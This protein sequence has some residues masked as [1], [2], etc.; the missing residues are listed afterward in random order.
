MNKRETVA[1]F[2]L[3]HILYSCSTAHCGRYNISLS[4]HSQHINTLLTCACSPFISRLLS[5]LALH[6]HRLS[7]KT[8]TTTEHMSY[9]LVCQTLDAL[10]QR[11]RLSSCLSSVMSSQLF[12]F[13]SFANQLL[14]VFLFSFFSSSE[15]IKLPDMR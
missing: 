4:L 11:A 2:S 6:P 7:S 13:L 12:Y 15:Y 9:C 14:L 8:T 1:R 10:L 3:A 5:F